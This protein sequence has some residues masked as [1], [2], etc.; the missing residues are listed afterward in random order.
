M[1]VEEL[2]SDEE[3]DKAFAHADFGRPPR[4]VVRLGVLKA[5]SGFYQGYTSTAILV[6]LNLINSDYALTQKGKHYLWKA[7]SGGSNF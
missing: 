5:A 2:V 1:T 4:E 6:E 3:L 7:W